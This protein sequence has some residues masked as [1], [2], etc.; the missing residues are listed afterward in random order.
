MSLK[1]RSIRL[2]GP[3]GEHVRFC[4]T[5]VAKRLVRTGYATFDATRPVLR[6]TSGDVETVLH[7]LVP[8]QCKGF[9]AQVRVQKDLRWG[10]KTAHGE[11]VQC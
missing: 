8:L 6:L 7:T 9:Q 1:R 10:R 5:S 11:Y 4:R 3:T 2:V